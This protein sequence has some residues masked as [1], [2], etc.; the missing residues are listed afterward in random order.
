MN[1][2]IKSEVEPEA[3]LR[4]LIHT[5]EINCRVFK[6]GQSFEHDFKYVLKRTLLHYQK[7]K[8]NFIK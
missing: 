2:K 1:K 4:L 6:Y 8:I 3:S 5:G 7:S